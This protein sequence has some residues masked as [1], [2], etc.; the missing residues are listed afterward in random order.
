ME[1]KTQVS[2]GNC[3]LIR[4]HQL[5]WNYNH[6]SKKNI[7]K[8]K[9]RQIKIDRKTNPRASCICICPDWFITDVV[10]QNKKQ[11]KMSLNEIILSIRI[12]YETSASSIDKTSVNVLFAETCLQQSW[13]SFRICIS[14]RYFETSTITQPLPLRKDPIV[15]S[16]GSNWRLSA[17]SSTIFPTEHKR[18]FTLKHEIT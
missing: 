2:S 10:I 9:A 11:G 17:A 14:R 12:I 7:A 3:L 4:W 8:C 13:C 1:L 15:F 5:Y 16:R 18:I 6:N